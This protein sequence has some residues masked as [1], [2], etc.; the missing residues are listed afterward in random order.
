MMDIIVMIVGV[1]LGFAVLRLCEK[2][3]QDPKKESK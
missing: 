3:L 1:V 2:S